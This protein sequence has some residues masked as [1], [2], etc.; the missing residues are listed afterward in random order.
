M[1]TYPDPPELPIT[2]NELREVQ[3]KGKIVTLRIVETTNGFFVDVRKQGRPDTM[4]YLATRREADKPRRFMDLIRLNKLLR[5]IY[6][7]GTIQ[8]ECVEAYK[9]KKKA[10]KKAKLKKKSTTK[11]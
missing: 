3:K 10:K 1:T 11:N 5:G 2:L 9:E 7:T 4:H 8:L 6:P